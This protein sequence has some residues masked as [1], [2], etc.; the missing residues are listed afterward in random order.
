MKF[1][2]KEIAKSPFEV[3][4]EGAAGDASKV[5]AKGPGIEKS[6]VVATKKTWFEVYTKGES[7]HF[8]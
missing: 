7:S 1:A 5:S 4:V 8:F 6:G 3:Q 2:L